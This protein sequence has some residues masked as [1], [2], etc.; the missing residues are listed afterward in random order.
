MDWLGRALKTSKRGRKPKHS[1]RSYFKL[2]VAKEFK[3]ASLRSAETDYSKE[4]CSTR[5]DHSVIH[6]WEKKFDK[7]LIERI[8][9]AAGNKLEQLLGYIFSM[10]DATEFTLWNKS[11]IEFHLFNHIASNT[12]YPIGVFFGNTAPSVATAGCLNKGS[13]HLYGDAWYDDNKSFRIMIKHGYDPVVKANKDRR[14]GYWRHRARKL[15][16]NLPNRFAYSNRGRG[17]SV[18][19][20]LANWFGDRLKTSRIDTS[21]TRIGARIV[22]YLVKI[23]MRINVLYGIVRH[24]RYKQVHNHTLVTLFYSLNSYMRIRKSF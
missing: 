2:I 12:L 10:I 7:L 15:W 13:G 14:R 21:I 3:K 16:N 19:G 17:E 11:N 23:Y 4:V 20:T 9:K 1:I 8:V 5:V 22:A 24:A 6:Y 18:F